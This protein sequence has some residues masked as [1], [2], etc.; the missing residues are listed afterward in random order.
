[1]GTIIQ[2]ECCSPLFGFDSMMNYFS[3]TVSDWLSIFLSIL[4]SC[5]WEMFESLEF[6]SDINI[7]FLYFIDSTQ[8]SLITEKK[9]NF[10]EFLSL[11]AL[12]STCPIFP[13]PSYC[14]DP[15]RAV[16][17]GKRVHLWG[18]FHLPRFFPLF[19]NLGC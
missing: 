12:D 4:V 14:F 2:T 13:L 17:F 16:V 8:A 5:I 18:A 15:A 10:M 7:F 9:G 6:L 11:S 1:M 3:R 19:V